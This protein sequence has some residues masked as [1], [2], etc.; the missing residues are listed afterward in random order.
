MTDVSN[1]IFNNNLAL[2]IS[3]VK[4]DDLAKVLTVDWHAKNYTN[5]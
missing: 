2:E 5:G 1:R 4:L 3:Y